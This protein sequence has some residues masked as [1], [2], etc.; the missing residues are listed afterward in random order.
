[1]SSTPRPML[2]A[3]G[4]DENQPTYGIDSRRLVEASRTRGGRAELLELESLT[5]ADT[6]DALGDASSPL[7]QACLALFEDVGL[8]ASRAAAGRETAPRRW[9]QRSC[10]SRIRSDQSWHSL[11]RLTSR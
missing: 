9:S 8:V 6:A 4:G 3:Y 7:F 11:P 10:S 1:M 2:V 5:H